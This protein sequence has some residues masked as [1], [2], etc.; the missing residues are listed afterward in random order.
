PTP[1]ASTAARRSWTMSGATTYSSRTARWTCTSGGCATRW[2]PAA[3]TTSSRRC[4][5]P[6][7]ASSPSADDGAAVALARRVRGAAPG[8]RLL[9]A[10]AHEPGELAFA[11]GGRRSAARVRLVGRPSRAA[12]P[13]APGGAPAR[14]GASR[15][16][17]ALERRG[18]R[19]AR[20]RRDTGERAH[21]LVQRDRQQPLPHRSHARP[22]A[23]GDPPRARAGAGEVPRPRRFHQADPDA[24]D[25]AAGS[26]A[27]AA[28]RGLW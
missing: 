19:V 7:T 23:A 27:L 21:R 13:R 18:A 17:R 11:S 6:D 24:P 22:G 4:A 2:S 14:G 5:A 1:T 25:R 16:P 12:A 9:P 26:A 28:G 3:T 15:G 8:A 20:R 10:Q